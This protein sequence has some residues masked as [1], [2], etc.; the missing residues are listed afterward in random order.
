M[1]EDLSKLKIDRERQPKIVKRRFRYAYLII[2]IVA[3]ASGFYL[4]Y[5]PTIKVR[6]ST[7]TLTYPSQSLAI[8]NASGYVVAQRK[9]ALASKTTGRLVWLGVEEGDF[10]K[11]DQII[12]R[13]EN[14]DAIAT[15]NQAEANVKLAESNL[16]SAKAE[17]DDAKTNLER[18][19]ILFQKSFATQSELDAAN[20]R[21]KR[22]QAAVDS[23]IASLNA[24]KAAFK[25]A[26]VALEYT[27]IRAP[28][29][30]VV[31]TKNA[32]IGDIITPLGAAANAKAAVVTIADLTS[33]LVEADVSEANI[34][35]VKVGQPCS[36]TL[37]AIPDK[38]FK[39]VVHMIVPTADRTKASIMIKV[40]FLHKDN[41]VLPEMGAKVSFLSRQPTK[42]EEIERL[43]VNKFAIVDKD[44]KK[45]VFLIK[46][47]RAILKQVKL[48]KIF[49][50]EVEI[51]EG[52]VASDKVVLLPPKELKNNSKITLEVK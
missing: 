21:Y 7:V 35:S 24:A 40:K 30:G 11:R 42:E 33:L 22:A 5:K 28:F 37:D 47:D 20:L 34:S 44:S 17:L 23:S 38:H 10:V 6:S 31:L 52:L 49:G 26:E 12:A 18:Q 46:D 25:S 19:K 50:E 41:H 51:L 16:E 32:D 36:I 39:G 9:A 3:M 45:Y 14:E 8:L 15:K 2:L 1:Q 13:L 43:T 27:L 29:D 48:G 4:F